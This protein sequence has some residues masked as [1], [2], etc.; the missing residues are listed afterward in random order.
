MEKTEVVSVAQVET[1]TKRQVCKEIIML[2]RQISRHSKCDIFFVPNDPIS[3]RWSEASYRY[4][5]RRKGR[6][7]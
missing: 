1:K 2:A 6:M 7:L 5:H 3:Q 4:R